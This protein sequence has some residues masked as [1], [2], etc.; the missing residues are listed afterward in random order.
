MAISIARVLTT[1]FLIALTTTTSASK[2]SEQVTFQG[3]RN[4][5]THLQ[6][7]VCNTTLPKASRPDCEALLADLDEEEDTDEFFCPELCFDDAFNQTVTRRVARTSGNCRLQAL[8]NILGG[9]DG[10][11]GCDGV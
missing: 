10:P 11:D 6:I 3:G 1:A 7:Y 5:I 2:L 9:E 4:N 8:T